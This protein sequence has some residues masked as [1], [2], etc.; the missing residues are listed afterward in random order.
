MKRVTAEIWGA[1]IQRV[2]M[3]RRAALRIV[4]LA[5]VV[6]SVAFALPG[7]S[8]DAFR[9]TTPAGYD[10]IQLQPSGALV[11][12][13]GL[14]E[15]PQL[16]GAQRLNHGLESRIV[17]SDGAKLD[18]FPRQFSVRVTASLRKAL[19]EEPEFTV[20]TDKAP[21]DFLL[22]L[23]FRLQ[24]YDGLDHHV[25]LPR[26]VTMIGAP[27]TLP[28]NERIYR[29]N[30]DVGDRPITSRFLLEVFSPKGEQIGRFSFRLL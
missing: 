14:F 4:A 20:K 1:A 22:G 16:Q 2:A 26:S 29:L 12:I 21:G 7:T 19:M 8:D 13:L 6:A 18:R 11:A 5:A 28:Y 10:V 23:R 17:L 30:F 27:A 3:K 15:C 25:I 24:A 9:A